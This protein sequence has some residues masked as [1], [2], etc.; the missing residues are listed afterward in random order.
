MSGG[1][2]VLLARL[3][4]ETNTFVEQPTLAGDFERFEGEALLGRRGDGSPPGAF[5]E[6]ALRA[7]WDVVPTL[8]WSCM[9][10]GTVENAVFELYWE[11]LEPLLR[12]A[13]VDGLDGCFM[14]LHGAM[15][16]AGVEDVE[17]ELLRRI[18]G[19]RG[20]EE[21]P[22][23][24]VL[25][26]HAN[27]TQLMA[28]HADALFA[29]RE[30]PHI[31]AAETTLRAARALAGCMEN[32]RRPVTALRTVDILWPATGTATADQPMR[33][34]EAMA[35]RFEVGEGV[36]EVN[37]CPGFAH[38]DIRD[39]GV[40]FSVSHTPG[41]EPDSILDALAAQ[42]HA[43]RAQGLPKE[44]ELD[45]AIDD[46]L[47]KGLFPACLVESAD[48]IGGGAPGDGTAALRAFVERG[49]EGAF[50]AINDPEGV[51]AARLAGV[52]GRLHLKIG[53]KGFSGDAGPLGLE[54][55]VVRLT[56]GRFE[57]E[58]RQ[59]HLASM[60]GAHI[61][62][63][64]CAVVR[65]GGVTVLLTSRKTPP[66]DLG[67]VRSQGIDPA[68]CSLV[69]IKAAVAY[70]RAWEKVAAAHYFVSVPGPCS[71]DLRSLPFRRVRRPIYPLDGED[72]RG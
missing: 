30:N 27:V 1:R 61:D 13:A 21:T 69:G 54:V 65:H 52:G 45:A 35:R 47:A 43:T 71:S 23:F 18:R 34:L 46:A 33:E 11:R 58:D 59:S 68:R 3:F 17:G 12:R 15:A 53:G 22:M 40:T 48:N 28:R 29:Y 26:L 66:F 5:L 19:V 56:E 50:A 62:M 37:V 57:L 10:S 63:G 7:G 25:D 2:R 38:S 70:R 36:V 14:I 24:A 16:C 6:F 51:R 32:G 31:D 55:E 49:V 41:F 64:P 60:C 67:M 9:P 20:L 39:A 44:W 72:E 42:A 4:H 8:D